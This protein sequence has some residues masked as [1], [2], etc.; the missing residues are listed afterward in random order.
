MFAAQVGKPRRRALDTTFAE[1]FEQWYANAAPGWALTKQRH[2]RSVINVHLTPR[3][4]DLAVGDLTTQ[5]IDVFYSYLRDHGGRNGRG[6]ADGTVHRIHG[7]LRRSLTQAVR[8]GWVWTDPAEHACPP[9]AVKR[10]IFSPPPGAVAQLLATTYETPGLH[11]FFRLA[12]ST[13][14][15]RGQVCTLRWNDLDLDRNAVS[16]SC[17]LAEGPKGGLEIVPTKNRKRN[18]VEVDDATIDEVRRHRAVVEAQAIAA[19]VELA[20]DTYVFARDGEGT[21]A[22]RSQSSRRASLTTASRPDSTCTPMPYLAE[23]VTPLTASP[24]FSGAPR[25]T[26]L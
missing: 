8:W 22:Y 19:G 20:P 6:L 7:V 18:R 21:A 26:A 10:E 11:T 24:R 25:L 4:G 16:F 5:D 1:L 9:V 13:G 23:T 12:A 2:T 17:S 14:A 15:R 3:F